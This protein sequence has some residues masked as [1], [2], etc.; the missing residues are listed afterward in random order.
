MHASERKSEKG[1]Y[2]Y[3]ILTFSLSL[4]GFRFSVATKFAECALLEHCE[5]ERKARTRK[6]LRILKVR[7]PYNFDYKLFFI[8]E[9]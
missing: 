1:K 6:F 5:M 9:N 8:Y 2:F 7:L 4:C 3:H